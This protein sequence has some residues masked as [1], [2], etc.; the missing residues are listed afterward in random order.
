MNRK[1]VFGIAVFLG[2]LGLGLLASEKQAVAGHGCHGCA[3]GGCDGGK[4]ACKGDSGKCHGGG[5]LGGLLGNRCHGGGLLGGRCSGGKDSCAGSGKGNGRCHGGGLLS[6]LRNRCHGGGSCKGGDC[7]GGKAA[8]EA[9][10][11]EE[12]AAPPAAQVA[13]QSYVPVAFRS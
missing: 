2:L 6:R 5:L 3:G 4:S 11:A 8:D 7:G 10:A 1:T 13:P 12:P 9:P